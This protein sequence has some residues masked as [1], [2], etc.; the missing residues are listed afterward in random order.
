M[1]T[2]LFPILTTIVLG[3]FTLSSCNHAVKEE[4][5]QKIDSLNV[6]LNYVLSSIDK[7]DPQLLENRIAEID[8][9]SN[10]LWENV[11]DTLPKKPGMAMGDLIRTNKYLKQS[12]SRYN[13]ITKESSYSRDQLAALKKDVENSFYSDEEFSGYFSTEASSITELVK[14]TDEL[15]YKYEYSTGRYEKNKP[16]VDSMIDS[17]KAVIYSNE[18]IGK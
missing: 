18:P 12:L 9:L 7:I 11:A 14:A 16:L 10:W 6:H 15:N 2:I 5:I 3:I 1:K 13:D 4:R 17:I 8:Q